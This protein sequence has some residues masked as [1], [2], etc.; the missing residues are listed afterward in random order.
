MKIN[1]I[2][3]QIDIILISLQEYIKTSDQKQL[4]YATYESLLTQ[5]QNY[6]NKNITNIS[7]NVINL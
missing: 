1:L 5:K 6:V 7:K 3:K 4:I 2:D